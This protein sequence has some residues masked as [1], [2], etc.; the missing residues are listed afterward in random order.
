MMI[1]SKIKKIIAVMLAFVMVIGSGVTAFAE[2][3]NGHG[4]GDGGVYVVLDAGQGEYGES[5]TTPTD[6][7]APNDPTADNTDYENGYGDYNGGEYTNG[8]Y[9]PYENGNG[10]YIGYEDEEKATLIAPTYI[11]IMPLS[12]TVIIDGVTHHWSNIQNYLNDVNNTLIIVDMPPFA[13]LSVGTSITLTIPSGTTL[14]MRDVFAFIIEGTLVNN[15]TLELDMPTTIFSTGVLINNGTLTNNNQL[16]NQGGVL[17]NYGTISGPGLITSD[18]TGTFTLTVRNSTELAQAITTIGTGTGTIRLGADII[19]TSQIMINGGANITLTSD[20]PSTIRT[21]TAN[22]SGTFIMI[23]QGSTFILENIDINGALIG[24]LLIVIQAGGGT[25][26][27]LEMRAGA[28]LR[29]RDNTAVSVNNGIFTMN[30]GEIRNNIA[31]IN[32]G[33]VHIGTNGTFIM[34]GGTIADNI[35]IFDTNNVHVVTGGT[36]IFNNGTIAGGIP[37]IN[38][39]NNTSTAFGT[40]D[41]FQVTATSTVNMPITFALSGQ[42]TGVD[43]NPTTGII[44][45]AATTAGG[46]HPFGITATNEVGTSTAQNFTLTVTGGAAPVIT[47]PTNNYNS[48]VNVDN[49]GHIVPTSATNS[50]TSWAITPA[51]SVP[52]SFNTA[53]G[54]FGLMLPTNAHIGIHH[55]TLTATNA[56]GT[57][58]PISF[59]ITINPS[60]GVGNFVAVTN[61]ASVNTTN[62]TA[63]HTRNLSGIIEPTNAT[64]IVAGNPIVWSVFDAGTTGATIT[65]NNLSTPNAGTVVVRATVANGTAVGTARTQDFTIV[66]DAAGLTPGSTI[67]NPPTMASRTHNSITIN[68]AT[69]T[70]AT[71]QTI[72]YAISTNGTTAPTTGWQNGLTFTGLTPSTQYFVWARSA[73]NA[74]HYA[75]VAVASAGITTEAAQATTHTITFDPNNGIGTMPSQTV[76]NGSNFTIP[77]NTFTR[78]NHSFTGWNT[79]ANGTGTAFAAGA[80]ITNVTANMNLFAQWTWIGGTG[81]GTGNGNNNDTTPNQGWLNPNNANLN[82][83]NPTNITVT[84]NR[85]D[86]TFQNAI[87][88]GTGTNAINL[89]RDTDFTVNGNNITIMADWL[90]EHMTVGTRHL[91]FVM[92]GNNTLSLRVNVTDTRPTVTPTPYT[93]QPSAPSITVELSPALTAELQERLGDRFEA[94]EVIVTYDIAQT[95]PQGAA[96]GAV[97]GYYDV[98]VEFVVRGSSAD[99]SDDEIITGFEG[100]YTLYA[101]MTHLALERLN[102][103]HHRIVALNTTSADYRNDNHVGN[104]IPWSD[105]SHPAR[106]GILGGG[107]VFD[108]GADEDD[109]I[110]TFILQTN[111][112]GEFMI[113]YV[114]DLIRLDL[115]LNSAIIQ[116]LAGNSPTQTMDVL[117]IIQDG[118][119]IIPIRFIAE[120]LGAEVDW[121]PSTENTPSIAQ[122]IFNGQELLIPLDG[123]ITPQL[124]ALGMDVPAQVMDSRTMIPLRFVS[125]FFGAVVYWDN[126]LRSIEVVM[127]SQDAL[128]EASSQNPNHN[129]LTGRGSAMDMYVDRRAIE[130][131]EQA[132]AA[133]GADEEV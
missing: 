68:A 5:E 3:E 112:T 100:H 128:Q 64:S 35:S 66:V 38:S 43:I 65:G 8:E 94:L 81:T 56:G 70:T 95:T 78:A 108:T 36:F 26:G 91:T 125:E 22:F 120:A 121:L 13:N 75:G 44:S 117:P 18:S 105:A 84:L 82:L 46:T 14:H 2:Y 126:D 103:N 48:T 123:T 49:P 15:G 80:T 25:G 122:I 55:F 113:A 52:F 86:F 39:A 101:D 98:S 40:A 12:N 77:T 20:S 118:R 119:T 24:H 16:H 57:S 1:R 19:H 102:L 88:F 116:D 41:T 104:V 62:M 96:M 72:Q 21:L 110:A 124:Q 11:D 31:P 33:G 42:P 76:A 71:G 60:G 17:S 34:N 58:A 67:A 127:L 111:H 90:Y 63:G 7:T 54:E 50:P 10:D 9:E 130:E 106:A 93:P 30:G 51:V 59:T 115:S 37:T 89:V 6:E 87:R 53:T 4:G 85:G 83:A 74:T 47:S 132:L 23:E 92:S 133:V 61:I 79:L 114:R 107:V 69:L 97:H 32:G 109:V 73:A 27:N 99:G 28:T 29:Y 45:I 129:P 131:L